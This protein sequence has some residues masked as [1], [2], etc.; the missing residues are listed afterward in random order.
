MGQSQLTEKR[1]V[2]SGYW[3]LWRFNPTLIEQGKNPF[4][5]D[6]K[7]PDWSKFQEF[8]HREVRYTSLL[9]A[10]P[11]EAEELFAASQANA[12]WRYGTYKRFAAMNYSAT[13]E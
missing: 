13:E 1:A 9:K 6:S 7:E 11:A 4:S 8:I 2:E 5:L 10:F 12:Q 3:H